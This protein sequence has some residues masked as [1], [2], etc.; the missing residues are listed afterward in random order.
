MPPVC[1]KFAVAPA[2]AARNS[3]AAADNWPL[4]LRLAVCVAAEVALQIE[5]GGDVIG[6]AP[7]RDQSPAPEEPTH[8]TDADNWPLPPR[9]GQRRCCRSLSREQS[10]S[11]RDRSAPAPAVRF[12]RPRSRRTRPT[13]TPGRRRRGGK[14]CC[15]RTCANREVAGADW[16]R[17]NCV[18]VP[19]PEYPKY[20]EEADRRLLPLRPYAPLLPLLSPR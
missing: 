6:P 12:P 4:P 8:S 7:V 17:S 18:K 20:S 5:Q 19:V 13:R 15:C 14:R 1:W 11:W 10:R 3:L 16:S 9:L 2:V